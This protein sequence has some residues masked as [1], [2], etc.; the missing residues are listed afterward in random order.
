MTVSPP[1][2][3]LVAL[4][5]AIEKR[6]KIQETILALYRYARSQPPQG[7]GFPASYLLDH[8]SAASFSLWRARECLALVADASLSGVRTTI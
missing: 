8:L 1:K 5:W 6:A 4:E 2:L 7:P 3:D